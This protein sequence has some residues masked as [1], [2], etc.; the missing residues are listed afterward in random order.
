MLARKVLIVDDNLITRAM[1]RDIV[2]GAGFEVAVADSAETAVRAIVMNVP[3]VAIVDQHLG[4]VDGADFVRWLHACPIPDVRDVRLIGIS[5]RV[6]SKKDL[7]D[8][9]ACAFLAKPFQEDKLLSAVQTA[10]DAADAR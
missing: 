8:A 7:V 3:D 2:K 5:G 9:G 1:L 4:G 6:E 10:L